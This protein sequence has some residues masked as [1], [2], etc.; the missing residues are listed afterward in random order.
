M[1]E[2]VLLAGSLEDFLKSHMVMGSLAFAAVMIF[3]DWQDS[4]H[5]RKGDVLWLHLGFILLA[6]FT[7][8]AAVNRLWPCVVVGLLGLYVDARLLMRRIKAARTA[9]DSSD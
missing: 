1:S 4:K 3:N 6:A 2:L 8:G 5:I 7:A 9:S